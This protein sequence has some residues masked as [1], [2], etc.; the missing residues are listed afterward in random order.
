MPLY[1]PL[2][3]NQ[4]G[5][6]PQAGYQVG[7]HHRG[8]WNVGPAKS[9]HH[10]WGDSRA[11]AKGGVNRTNA[12]GV[13]PHGMD[14]AKGAKPSAVPPSSTS[15]W[16]EAVSTSCSGEA[17]GRGSPAAS[18]AFQTTQVLAGAGVGVPVSSTH[19]ASPAKY[20]GSGQ[21]RFI[22][23]TWS[24]LRRMVE[25]PRIMTDMGTAALTST[26]PPPP[27]VGATFNTLPLHTFTTSI[28][29]IV[30]VGM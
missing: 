21:D 28:C 23:A 3:G 6:A 30:L 24:W 25:G 12:G 2:Y 7:S 19:V 13:L 20:D 5:L 29:T 27:H 15:V 11:V 14:V 18:P 26:G 8:T 17:E 22:T 4:A 9:S 10:C 16:P 1:H